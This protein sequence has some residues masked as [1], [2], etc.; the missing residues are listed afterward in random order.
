LVNAYGPTETCVSATQY[1]M[2]AQSWQQLLPPP[3]GAPIPGV[4]V[5][6]CD[7]AGRPLPVG[8]AGEIRIGGAGVGR[9]YLHDAQ[10]SAARFVTDAQGNRWYRSGDLGRWLPDAQLQFIGR[11]DRQVKIRGNRI[12][13]GEIET[14]LNAQPFVRH[15]IVAAADPHSQGS[16]SLAAWLVVQPGFDPAVCRAELDTKLPAYM[17]PSWLIPVDTIPLNHHGKVDLK[18]LL[19]LISDTGLDL[20]PARPLSTPAEERVAAL[21]GEVLG[22]SIRDSDADFFALGGH[23]VLAVRLLALLQQDFGAKI[24]LT[25]LFTHSTVAR[26]AERIQHQHLF[27]PKK[28]PV[29]GLNTS[30]T[31]IPLICFHPVGGNVLC[32]QAL[33]EELGSDQPVYMVEAQ[34]LAEGQPPL[35]TVEEMVANYLPAVR[36]LLPSGPV[37]LAGWSFGGLLAFEAAYRL[38]RAGVEVRE[39]MLFDALA[40]ADGLKALLR[41]DESEYLALLFEEMGLVDAETLRALTPEERLDLL[42]ERGKGTDLLPLNSDREGMRRLLAVFQNN[43]LAAIR[44]TPPFLEKTDILLVRPKQ[45]KRLT[46]G[47]VGDDY[48]G[49]RGKVGGTVH[50]RWMEGSHGE[51]LMKPRICQLAA[52]VKAY[53]SAS[54]ASHSVAAG[55]P[56]L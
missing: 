14:A 20:K 10:L 41:K 40:N 28:T 19:R 45:L 6:I 2:T 24:P 26:L 33:A 8:V 3:I 31:A 23:S 48:N 30:G 39:I 15:S 29:V 54:G 34:G 17:I 21:M 47:I 51:M 55:L 32:Y 18:P 43:A 13:L 27:A 25:D 38:Y 56:L 49:W 35:A 37:R 11:E 53:L 5:Q 50:L 7:E 36:E 44:Y 52:H 16:V 1:F 42:V 22:Q 12:E 46:S 9:A 4:Q